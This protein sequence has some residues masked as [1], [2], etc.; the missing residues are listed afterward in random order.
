MSTDAEIVAYALNFALTVFFSSIAISKGLSD[1]KYEVIKGFIFS[2]VS[3][4]LWWVLGAL[5]IYMFSDSG[6]F[7]LSTM[8]VVFGFVFLFFGLGLMFYTLGT[9][10]RNRV[11]NKVWEM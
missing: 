8:Y 6:F 7:S 5:N 10:A 3:M 2:I 9:L 1:D 4:I 11:E